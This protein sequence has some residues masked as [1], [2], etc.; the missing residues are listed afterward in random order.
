MI[1]KAFALALT[2][3]RFPRLLQTSS[4]AAPSVRRCANPFKISLSILKYHEILFKPYQY[5]V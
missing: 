3:K 2:S 4:K 1:R 5:N